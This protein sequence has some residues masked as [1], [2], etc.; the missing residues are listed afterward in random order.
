MS[1]HYGGQDF[2]K[3]IRDRVSQGGDGDDTM[4]WLATSFVALWIV[5]L[6][7]NA[8]AEELI[9]LAT[10]LYLFAKPRD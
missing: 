6:F 2:G 5:S 7:L 4:W 10:F 9:Y 1:R 3:V 8:P